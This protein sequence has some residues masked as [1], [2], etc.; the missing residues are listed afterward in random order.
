LLALQ[1]PTF[2]CAECGTPMVLDDF[3][4]RYFAFVRR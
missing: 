4:D 3:P 2:A 1:P